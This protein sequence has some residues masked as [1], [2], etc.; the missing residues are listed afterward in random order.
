M[1]KK[2][3]SGSRD[4]I[5]R[6]AIDIFAERGKH[7][8]RMEEI[9]AKAKV[10]KAMVYYYFSTKKNLFGEVLLTV[11]RD[12]FGSIRDVLLAAP[13]GSPVERLKAVVGA[14]FD[15]FS[16]RPHYAKIVVQAIADDPRELARVFEIIR[17][18]SEVFLPE[19]LFS[20]FDDGI[21]QGAFRKVDPAQTMI[22]VIGLNLVYF[23]AAPIAQAVLNLRVEEG[24]DFMAER[25]KSILDLLL[26][27][28]LNTGEG[29]AKPDSVSGE[30]RLNR[31]KIE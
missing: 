12:I 1:I 10:N 15:A 7:G 28:V 31:I 5:I 16:R 23:V 18:E 21:K 22:S 30:K 26:H 20:V 9:G 27:G 8:A 19:R 17:R 6:A 2:A 13:P 25:K 4:R 24:L 3:S 14:H 29:D 11:I